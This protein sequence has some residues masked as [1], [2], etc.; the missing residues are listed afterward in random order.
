MKELKKLKKRIED[1]KKQCRGKPDS[2][3]L[4][5]LELRYDYIMSRKKI[6]EF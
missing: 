2:K 5:D 3:E 6:T 4:Q 1:L